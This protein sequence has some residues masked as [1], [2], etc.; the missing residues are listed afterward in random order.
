M[1]KMI[2]SAGVVLFLIAGTIPSANA[3]KVFQSALIG[4]YNQE[5]LF[6]T[7]NDPKINDEEFLP[8]GINHWN[9]AKYMRKLQ[10]MSEAIS[11]IGLSV[12]PDGV[13]VLGI[14]EIENRKVIED[15][16]SMPALKDRH[17]QIVH[18]NS[19]D[20]RGVDVALLYNPK[21]LKVL[22]T[23]S[24]RL[25]VKG[26]PNFRTRDQLLV[27][28]SLLGEKIYFI[29]NHW[30]S[31]YGGEKRSRPLRDAAAALSRHISDSLMAINPKAKIIVMGDLNDNPNNESVL[32][33][34][35]AVGS[36]KQMKGSDF[37]NPMYKLYKSGNGTTA[38]RDTWSLFDQILLSPG[39]MGKNYSTWEYYKVE[40]FNKQF[41]VQKEGR[42]KGYP[43]RSFAGGAWMGG[44][45]DHFPV[46]VVLIRE[47][48]K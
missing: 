7:V 46:Y 26:M 29:V 18:Y 48:R 40:V 32:K 25:Y 12:N 30:P 3:Q 10:H 23:K 13:A 36:E 38:W 43:Y 19:P 9:T 37:F 47:L 28:G 6:D 16:I 41:L 27:E 34:M 35:K 39:L 42:Y 20:R 11:K 17:Y 2:L 5:N 15:L 21:Y 8:D 44:Y 1:K 45:S 31:R 33:I 24:T 4:F 14:S 22:A